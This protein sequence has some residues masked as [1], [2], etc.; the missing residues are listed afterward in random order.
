VSNS[1]STVQEEGK[2]PPRPR[3][4]QMKI[5]WQPLWAAIKEI[6][7]KCERCCVDVRKPLHRVRSDVIDMK[8]CGSCAAERR[9]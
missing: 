3:I 5:T 9:D 2:G 7:M 8:V 4:R 6:A 1:R